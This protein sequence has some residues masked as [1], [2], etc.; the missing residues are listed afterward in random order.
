VLSLIAKSRLLVVKPFT[1][2]MPN[3]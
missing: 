1:D 2:V 3:M